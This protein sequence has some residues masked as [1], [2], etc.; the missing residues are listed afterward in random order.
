[1]NTSQSGAAGEE[2]AA[3]Y[4]EKKGYTIVQRN[5]RR[6]CGE[7]DLIALDGKTLV[8]VEVKKRASA[9]FGG[10]FGAVTASKQHKI[11]N[12]AYYFIKEKCPKFDSIRFDVVGLLGEQITHIENAFL[13]RRGTF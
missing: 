4:L 5:Y 3:R 8:F 10:P 1:M 9:A 7:I 11:A 6:V 2:A 13:P 12:T